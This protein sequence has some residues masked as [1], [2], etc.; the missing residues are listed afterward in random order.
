MT[1][2]TVAAQITPQ[3]I[4]APQ[5][6]DILAY[7]QSQFR[8]I[9][10]ADIYIDPDSQDGQ[11][12]AVIAQGFTDMNSLALQ[13]YNS[14]SPA[15]A[16]GN[17]LA[18]NVKINGIARLVA[19]YSTVDVTIVGTAGTTITNGVVADAN[20]NK[21]NLPASVT[22]PSGGSIVATATCQVLGAIGAAA[23]TVT[24]IAT[25]TLG[26][27]SV[28][29][30]AAAALGAP[31][32]SDA[33]LRTRQAHSTTL[34]SQAIT[35]GILGNIALLPN[36]TRWAA[37][38]NS[39]GTADSNGIPGHSVSFVVE[40]GD[41]LAI[42][43]TIQKLKTPGT[44]TYGTT[45]QSVV[46]NYGVTQS[47]NF[48]RPVSQAI[49]VAIA[50]KSLTGYSSVV[51]TAIQNAVSAFIN[52][53][54]IGGGTS[55]VV[56]WDQCLVAARNIANANSFKI[57]SLTL[58]GTVP[59]PTNGALT[60][61]AAGALAAATYYVK[62]TWVTASGE[63]LGSAETSL[64]VGANNV[65]NVAAPSSPPPGATGWNVYVSTS[66]GTETKQNASTIALGTAWVEPT[67]GL[68]SG[69]ALPSSNTAGAGTPDVPLAFNQVATC[70]PASVTLT[71]T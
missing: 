63:T 53:I 55:G 4:T 1:I 49:T 40:G 58:T 50:V 66:T 36:V 12:L 22:I 25:P 9:Y 54:Q 68:I 56:E 60:A 35:D 37:F 39:S 71:V 62:S 18:S 24:T 51:G 48:N 13:I 11:F 6:A 57:T 47:I 23:G 32:E 20:R 70:A 2:T 38:E 7:L 28:T 34:A 14:F 26:W 67:S 21:W 33:A 30:A 61:S 59:S 46:T 69:A 45:A 52:A 41:A 29:N 44:G 42:A 65:L 27:Q 16:T 10:G 3:G 15:T 64:A 5:F 31:V 8:S 19:S 43:Q 17:A